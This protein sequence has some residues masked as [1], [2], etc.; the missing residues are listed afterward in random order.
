MTTQSIVLLLLALVVFSALITWW[1]KSERS[2]LKLVDTPNHRSLHSAPVPRSGGVA[3][4]L[5]LCLGLMIVNWRL[6]NVTYLSPLLVAILIVAACSFLDDL[7]GLSVR[8][9]LLVHFLA[10]AYLLFS[11]YQLVDVG[12]SG[13]AIPLFPVLSIA[14]SAIFII[15]SINMY[16]FMDGMDGFAA[17]M[18]AFGFS[19]FA[20]LG[21]HA[22]NLPFLLCNLVLVAS[23]LGFW[24]Y[25][26]PPAKIFLGDTGSSVLGLCYGAISIWGVNE[27]VF[28][29]WVAII[30]F[31]PFLVDASYTLI[32]RICTG[33]RFWEAHKS[34]FYQRLVEKGYGHRKVVLGEYVLMSVCTLIAVIITLNSA[35]KTV[36]L[37]G[38]LFVAAL[39][40]VLIVVLRT[41]LRRQKT[42]A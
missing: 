17:G 1:L 32:R 15:W 20:I 8:I 12:V 38:I 2:L 39:Y 4:V 10:V 31:S 22:N 35:A 40:T 9:R 24:F 36:Q 7:K 33:E 30:I 29:F 23:V 3:V 6:D 37:I 5:C 18:T 41:H 19:A 16:N 27:N 21:L 28:S 25:N 26:F 13:L 42:S 14:V 34:H 11:G